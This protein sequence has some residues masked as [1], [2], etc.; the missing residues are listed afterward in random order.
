MTGGYARHTLSPADLA[1]LGAG[2]VPP[3]LADTLKR[4][5]ASRNIA[6]LESVRRQSGSAAIDDLWRRL[7]AHP[8]QALDV[9]ISPQL[10]AWAD[11]ALRFG[12][13][14][15]GVLLAALER[16]RGPV[17]LDGPRPLR[18]RFET[19]EPLRGH[20]GLAVAERPGPA[21][22][23]ELCRQAYRLLRARHPRVAAAM[24]ELVTT[25]VP[26]VPPAPPE[27]FSATSGAA[28]G[29]VALSAPADAAELAATFTHE[30]QHQ[31][32]GAADEIVALTVPGH[33]GRFAVHWRDGERDA[34]A[35]LQGI[36]AHVAVVEFHRAE[37]LAGPLEE[38][39]GHAAAFA[40]W[41]LATGRAMEQL[42]RSGA[43]TP[44]GAALARPLEARIRAALAEPVPAPAARAA[45][46][47][48]A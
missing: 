42:G 37:W 33:P 19:G 38:R 22:W 21:D 4:A 48:L 16:E 31:V 23:T 9:L 11:D 41:R 6:L 32:L 44:A 35:T 3:A 45:E 47:A 46:A 10:G 26:V 12:S 40:L 14:D 34:S 39:P 27:T 30:L 13:G 17:A 28:F 29:A 18:L 15:T 2:E 20:F 8:G 36:F 5:I 43:L 7:G 1:G 25:V 24:A